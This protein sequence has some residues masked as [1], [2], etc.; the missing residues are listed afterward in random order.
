M[1]LVQAGLAR[2][3]AISLLLVI[4]WQLLSAA[5]AWADPVHWTC[6]SITLAVALTPGGP[7]SQAV[8]GTYCVPA[9]WAAGPHEADVLTPG[10]TY[11]GSYWDWPTDPALYSYLDKTLRAGRA[12]LD[13]D[14]IGT[15]ASSHPLSTEISIDTDAYVLHQIVAWLRT[16]RSYRRINLIGHS[17]GS[18][19][20]IQ[21][22][23]HYQDVSRVVLTGLLHEPSIGAGFATTLLSLLYPAELDPQFSD[24]G[25]D[26]GYLTTMPFTRAAAF[27]SSTAD[28][29]VIA[30]DEAHKDVVSA[31]DLSS[32]ASTWG[33]PPGPNMSDSITA[34]VLV[35]IGARDAIFC[36][37]PPALD[38][39]APAEL[40]KSESPYYDSAASLTIYSIPDTGHDIA[41]HPS[42]DLSFAMIND[43]ISGHSTAISHQTTLPCGPG[44]QPHRR[45]S[46]ATTISPR[47]CS[48]LASHAHGNSS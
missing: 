2:D 33:L 47:P 29:A 15:G 17:L 31:T 40:A 11:N 7:D 26:P 20:S 4:G 45:L 6:Q 14:R 48:A 21:E 27:Y 10:A 22:A 42:A 23:G 24:R 25:L 34:P 28:P 13:Y 39:R 18:V 5:L 35:V 43:W 44:R 16:S 8:L 30:Y 3:I 9:T 38:C 12:T 41:L 37:A 32:L 36:T 1:K 19:I 46:A